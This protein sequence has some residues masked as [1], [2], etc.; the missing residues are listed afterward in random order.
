MP[1]S[2][3]TGSEGRGLRTGRGAGY[4]APGYA[5][6]VY[7]D[8]FGRM[9]RRGRRWRHWFD[10]TGLLEWLRF[11]PAWWGSPPMPARPPTGEEIEELKAQAERLQQELDE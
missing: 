2:D 1:A 4:H 11:R 9:G 5:N 8:G 7:R 10:E 6:P 3:G